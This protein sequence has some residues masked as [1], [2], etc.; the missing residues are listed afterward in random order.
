MNTF[1]IQGGTKS[2]RYV[3]LPLAAAITD[4]TGGESGSK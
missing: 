4:F 3:A 1:A 2:D